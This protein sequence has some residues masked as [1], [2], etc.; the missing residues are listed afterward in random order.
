MPAMR[1]LAT[2]LLLMLT[3][4]AVTG[5]DDGPTEPDRLLTFSGTFTRANLTMQQDHPFSLGTTS[6][7]RIRLTDGALH[8]PD[9]PAINASFVIGLGRPGATNCVPSSSVVYG[10]G[11]VSSHGL[12]GGSYCLAVFSGTLLPAPPAEGEPPEVVEP[13]LTYT[14]TAEITE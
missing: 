2:P 13:T 3:I 8:I 10:R 12:R 1:R 14:I 6:N 9:A 7:L 5:C 4:L 11:D